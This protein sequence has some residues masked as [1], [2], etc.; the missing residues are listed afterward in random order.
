MLPV[1]VYIRF[2]SDQKKQHEI[3]ENY[4]VFSR[5]LPDLMKNH[6]GKFVVMRH[7]KPVEFF[8]TA[9]DAMV[10]A[11]KTYSDGLFSVQEVTQKAVDLGW[12]SHAPL[13]DS[14]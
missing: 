6:A 7:Q 2:M 5:L 9:R 12:F 13:H 10:Y 1:G 3:D 11:S 14:V 4:E 8:D